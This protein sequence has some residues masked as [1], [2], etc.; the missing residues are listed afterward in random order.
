MKQVLCRFA[1]FYMGEY[2]RH[3]LARM[4]VV[5]AGYLVGID[6]FFPFLVSLFAS[7]IVLHG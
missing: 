2:K 1:G 6:H 3:E 5:Q 4:A 7:W